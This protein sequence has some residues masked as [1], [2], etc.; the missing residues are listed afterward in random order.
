MK[1]P[2]ASSASRADAARLRSL[3]ERTLAHY[4]GVAESFWVGTRD[5]DVSQNLQALLQALPTRP[6]LRILDLGCGPGRD[7]VTLRSLGHVPVGLDGCSAFVRMAREHSGC[8]VLEQSFLELDLPEQSFD[9]VF[10]NASLFH[11]PRAELPRILAEL[12]AALVPGGAL[13]CSNPR[14]MGG[15]REGWQGERYGTYLTLESWSSLFELAGFSLVQHFLRPAGKPASE[16]PWLA[17]VLRK[18]A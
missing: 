10:A 13:F 2:P 8:E 11:A 16:Q 14:A 3:A 1:E 9:G 7:L 4:E 12:F 18:P 6:G 5:H 17:M 15:E